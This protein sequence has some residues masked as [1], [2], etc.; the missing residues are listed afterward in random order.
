VYCSEDLGAFYLDV[1]KDRL[2]TTAPKSLARRSAQ[3]ALWHITQAMLR[4]MA[5]FLSFTAEEA[6]ATSAIELI[7]GEEQYISALKASEEAKMRTLLAL[8]GTT[9]AGRR[10]IPRPVWALH[11]QPVRRGRTAHGGLTMARA[12]QISGL[13]A[14][15]VPGPGAH[16]PG[17]WLGVGCHRAGPDRP[18]HQG[19][20]PGYYQ[21]GD[22]HPGHLFFNVVRAH[23]TARR[24]RSWRRGWLAALVLHR[25]WRGGGGLHHL[26]AAIT[27]RP[28]PVCV[29]QLA[30][31]GGGLWATWPT[32]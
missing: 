25:H 6:W 22:S 4:W 19:A 8:P 31:M 12:K 9:W 5:P 10:P 30:C 2:Y 17:A 11:Q 29:R 27:C 16:R 32:G 24:F 3:T 28:A 1:L 15:F 14:T 23:N 13:R 7:A 18:V 21:L 20:D 26:D